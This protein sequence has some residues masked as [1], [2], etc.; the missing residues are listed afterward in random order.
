[1]RASSALA[2]LTLL[3]PATAGAQDHSQHV[4]GMQ[5]P[6]P[7]VA[8]TQGGQSAFAA[9]Q[10][11]ARLLEADP[12]TDWSTVNL[13]ALRRHLID[14]D[15]VTLRSRVTSVP[16]ATG[17]TFVVRGSGET[18]G[19]IKRMTAAHLQMVEMEDGPR[20]VRTELPDGVRLAVS[21]RNAGSPREVARI[22]GLGFIGLMTSGDHHQTHHLLMAK[23]Q[24]VHHGH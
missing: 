11:I 24:G 6:A 22:R 15:L 12:T 5:H 2:A 18:I 7:L 20:V 23:G 8:P 1:M 21:A 19:A 13:E 16:T 17:A 9:V 3:L 4:P 10:E 14:M